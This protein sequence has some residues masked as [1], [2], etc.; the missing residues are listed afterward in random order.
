[1]ARIVA[2]AAD[3]SGA[4]K[5][6]T[7]VMEFTHQTPRDACKA[8]PSAARVLLTPDDPAD[9]ADAE[10]EHPEHTFV[11]LDSDSRRLDAGDASARLNALRRCLSEA[12]G[13]VF[14]IEGK[15]IADLASMAEAL[16]Q[17]AEL[18]TRPG[19]PA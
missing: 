14:D 5:T 15:G 3:L 11:V 18:A 13:P 8:P 9:P 1:M 19:V 17:A 12:H 2:I 4:A 10:V 16:H 7:A 6:V